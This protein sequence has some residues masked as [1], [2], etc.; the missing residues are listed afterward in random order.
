MMP[1]EKR[2]SFIQS[3]RVSR[4]RELLISTLISSTTSP[5]SI[6]QRKCLTAAKPCHLSTQPLCSS[7]SIRSKPL[8]GIHD[9]KIFVFACFLLLDPTQ[10][11]YYP[12]HLHPDLGVL[13]HLHLDVLL[14]C[15]LEGTL[16]LPVVQDGAPAGLVMRWRWTIATL[17]S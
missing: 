5:V 6:C 13:W 3:S 14:W 7:F 1:F 17:T 11:L 16:Y 2:L 8:C 9:E 10:H 15:T 4:K 12:S